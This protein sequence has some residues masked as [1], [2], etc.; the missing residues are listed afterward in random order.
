[1]NWGKSFISRISRVSV[2][3]GHKLRYRRNY[4]K[5]QT[6]MKADT[7]NI[8][9]GKIRDNFNSANRLLRIIPLGFKTFDKSFLEVTT[10]RTTGVESARPNGISYADGFR[11]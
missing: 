4:R 6:Q 5:I 10:C 11:Y 3:I 9:S 8:L 1:M 7:V 2:K